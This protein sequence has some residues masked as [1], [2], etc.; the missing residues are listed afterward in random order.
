V[1][2]QITRFK[3]STSWDDMLAHNNHLTSSKFKVIPQGQMW[4]RNCHVTVGH[5][6]MLY[7]C[8]VIM[9][10]AIWTH[11]QMFLNSTIFV[12]KCWI[13]LKP[14]LGDVDGNLHLPVPSM[15]RLNQIDPGTFSILLFWTFIR[16]SFFPYCIF[17][18]SWM[19]SSMLKFSQNVHTVMG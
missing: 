11:L 6:V 8:H 13:L 3:C 10:T 18:R 14:V 15:N 17:K 1:E 2:F 19:V 7:T 16:D 5:L 4:Q 9:I 12:F